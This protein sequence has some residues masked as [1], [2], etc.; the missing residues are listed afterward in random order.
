MSL[1]E[2]N[3]LLQMMRTIILVELND[4]DEALF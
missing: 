4:P 1:W 2:L 3:S